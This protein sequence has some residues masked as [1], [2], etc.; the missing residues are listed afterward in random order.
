MIKV[1][2]GPKNIQLLKETKRN[3]DQLIE[4][5]IERKVSDEFTEYFEREFTIRTLKKGKM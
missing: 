4:K 1:S 5:Y 2:D 3:V